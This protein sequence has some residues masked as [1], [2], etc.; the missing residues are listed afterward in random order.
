MLSHGSKCRVEVDQMATSHQPVG[1]E[2]RQEMVL[3]FLTETKSTMLHIQKYKLSTQNG[4]DREG[5]K[6]GEDRNKTGAPR[7]AEDGGPGRMGSGGDG[8]PERERV[9]GRV[10]VR[11]GRAAWGGWGYRTGWGPGKVG[12]QEGGDPGQGGVRAGTPGSRSR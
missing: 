10:G 3:G 1:R 11:G 9:Q 4:G 5:D 6:G 2:T 8:S 12:P 7:G